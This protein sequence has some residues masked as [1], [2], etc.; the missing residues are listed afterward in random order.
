LNFR[1]LFLNI[2][3]PNLIISLLDGLYG[4]ETPGKSRMADKVAEEEY[5]FWLE[6]SYTTI[7]ESE[8]AGINSSRYR[9]K[10]VCRV[11]PGFALIVEWVP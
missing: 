11:V 7:S 6:T 8:A 9:Y 3:K 10:R 1:L 4:V 5:H 2:R